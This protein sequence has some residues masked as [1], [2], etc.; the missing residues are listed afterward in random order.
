MDAMPL[1]AL[2]ATAS[3]MSGPWSWMARLIQALLTASP[4]R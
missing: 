2:L 3:G 4:P 1:T